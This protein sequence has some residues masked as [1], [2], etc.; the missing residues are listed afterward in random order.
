MTLCKRQKWEMD[1]HVH[2]R[3]PIENRVKVRYYDSTFL[4]LRTNK[5]WLNHFKSI[6]NDLTLSKVNSQ[7]GVY[8]C[9]QC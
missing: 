5:D 1:L 6:T 9:T 4:G 3:D 7:S 8:E 2:Y